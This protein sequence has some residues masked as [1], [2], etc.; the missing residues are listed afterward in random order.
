LE[1]IL[2]AYKASG[3]TPARI[4]DLGTGSGALALALKKAFPASEVVAVT[5]ARTL[6]RS[7]GKTPP[8]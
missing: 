8:P 1:L 6:S 5:K 4:L 7:R 3:T 2:E